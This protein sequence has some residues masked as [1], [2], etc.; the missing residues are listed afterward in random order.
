MNY[1]SELYHHGVIGM[2]WGVR[3]YQPYPSGKKGK[4]I[5]EAALAEQR[6]K[7]AQRNVKK[8]TFSYE[9]MDATKRKEAQRQIRKA[10]KYL[11]EK[12]V[13]RIMKMEKSKDII[14]T[15]MLTRAMIVAGSTVVGSA[16]GTC[17]GKL[18]GTAL[19]SST[20][21]KIPVRA[22]SMKVITQANYITRPYIDTMDFLRNR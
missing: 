4:E 6:R 1:E 9:S 13:D 17:G 19:A 20:A 16:I 18:I 5:G 22:A 3:R 10:M 12:E 7:I 2:K 8:A 11:G 14:Y 15:T 21:L